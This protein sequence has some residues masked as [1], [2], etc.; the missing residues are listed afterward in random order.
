MSLYGA[1][2]RM[3]PYI[4]NRLVGG[5]LDIGVRVDRT[6]VLVMRRFY[7]SLRRTTTD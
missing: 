2:W 4:C 1:C 3:F 6:V 5:W 7:D